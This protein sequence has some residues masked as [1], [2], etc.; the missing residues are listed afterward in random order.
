[1]DL[2][3]AQP[4]VSLKFDGRQQAVTVSSHFFGSSLH[5][6]SFDKTMTRL[7]LFFLL[8]SATS[9]AQVKSD[10]SD[11]TPKDFMVKPLLER[12][13]YIDDSLRLLVIEYLKLKKIDPSQYFVDS[14]ISKQGDTLYIHLWDSRGLKRLKEIEIQNENSDKQISFRGNPGHCGT[15]SID[16]KRK[17][18]IHFLL[19]R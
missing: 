16:N 5:F 2:L 4:E 18:V 10:Y 14:T 15:I 8:I 13:N 6:A 3:W 11:I 19:W 17:K 1:M 12:A 7:I 9:F